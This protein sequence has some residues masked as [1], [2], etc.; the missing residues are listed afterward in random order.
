MNATSSFVIPLGNT[1]QRPAAGVVGMMRYNTLL[2]TVE[3][4]TLGN[5]WEAVGNTEFTLITADDFV[6]DDVETVFTLSE[7]ATTASV[8]VSINGVVQIPVTA[9]SVSGTTLTF[10]EAPAI[11][12]NIDVRILTTTATITA[13]SNGIGTA[14]VEPDSILPQVNITGDLIPFANA[15]YNVGSNTAAWNNLFLSGTEL[16]GYTSSNGSFPLQVNGQIFATNATIATSDRRYKENVEPIGNSLTLINSLSPVAF[17]WKQHSVH[18]FS[19][20]RTVGFIAQDVAEVLSSHSFADSIV[21][22][23][24][25]TLPDGSKEQFYGLAET[26]LI[27]LLVKA[28]QELQAELDAISARVN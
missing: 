23:N 26:S 2:D 28:I 25:V 18:N 9:Y 13:I 6:G 10:T 22:S 20:N 4:Y 16:I 5:G 8:I 24:E 12:D 11:G 7:T 1:L 21:Q 3:V 15:V 17:D 19:K 27:P 14:I